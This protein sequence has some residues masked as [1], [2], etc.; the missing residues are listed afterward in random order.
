MDY[1]EFLLSKRIVVEPSGFDPEHDIS[2]VLFD[3]QR[4]STRENED[5]RHI[6]PLQLEVIRRCLE[7]WTNPN[8][9]VLSPFAG[10]GSEGYESIKMGR[11][12]IGIE[13]KESYYNQAVLNLEAAEKSLSKPKQATLQLEE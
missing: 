11:R 12:F 6:A 7:L 4:E 1:K 5:E 10:I 13:L 8:D 3:F 2:P 9:I